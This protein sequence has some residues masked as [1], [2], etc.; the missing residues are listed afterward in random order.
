VVC[1]LQLPSSQRLLVNTSAGDLPLAL[2]QATAQLSCEKLQQ[3]QELLSSAIRDDPAPAFEDFVRLGYSEQYDAHV[4]A[5]DQAA[6]GMEDVT[7][8]LRAET[9]ISNLKLKSGGNGFF[10]EVPPAS[11]RLIPSSWMKI[12]GR[13][14]RYKPQQLMKWEAS[15]GAA[16]SAASAAADAIWCEVVAAVGQNNKEL[17][18]AA[19]AAADIDA[20]QSLAEVAEAHCHVRPRVQDGGAVWDVRDGR[21]FVIENLMHKRGSCFVPNSC[22]LSPPASVMLLSGANMGGK[23]TF[24]RQNALI[25]ILAQVGAFVPASTANISVV[26]RLYCRVGAFSWCCLFDFA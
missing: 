18:A 2:K 6:V 23:S 15:A 25:A 14:L 13:G 22:C 16:A 21:H 7:S 12:A 9:G 17:G 10:I 19:E 24:L 1:P 4:I 8:Q 5:R 26:D 3:L 20:L 11:A